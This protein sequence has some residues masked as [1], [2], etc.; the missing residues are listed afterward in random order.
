MQSNSFI[1]PNLKF[2]STLVQMKNLSVVLVIVINEKKAIIFSLHDF[3]T[4][5]IK[6]YKNKTYD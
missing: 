1:D 2:K 3:V 4:K 6:I 5:N